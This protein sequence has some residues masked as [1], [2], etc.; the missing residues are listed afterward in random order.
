[1]EIQPHEI[2]F[3]F[4]GVIADTFRLF[5]DMAKKDYNVDIDYEEITE[6]D[7]LTVVKMN[8]E[9]IAGLFDTITN[10]THELDLKPNEGAAEVL[11][12]LAE[13]SPPLSIV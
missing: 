3:D 9:D 7:F 8:Y 6:Y 2:A 11:A 10:H 13:K 12:R 1:M 4:D 5:V